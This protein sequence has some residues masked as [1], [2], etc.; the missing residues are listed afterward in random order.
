[1]RSDSTSS[2]SVWQPSSH[3]VFRKITSH[4]SD[5]LLF[6]RTKHASVSG[7]NAGQ[8]QQNTAASGK[9]DGGSGGGSSSNDG[10]R[11][12][13]VSAYSPP[14]NVIEA[15]FGWLAFYQ[16]LYRV[17][18]AGTSR[19]LTANHNTSGETADAPSMAS[20]YLMLDTSSSSLL[21]P[22]FREPET[23]RAYHAEVYLQTHSALFQA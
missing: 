22:T 17:P 1:M 6:F 10:A 18:C 9:G 7:S 2:N 3:A 21:P 4:A 15:L 11:S 12:S 5:A 8:G 23:G 14:A 19:A 13:S 16:D 20:A